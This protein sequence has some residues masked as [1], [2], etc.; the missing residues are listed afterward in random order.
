MAVTKIWPVRDNLKR[1]VEYAENPEKIFLGG[2]GACLPNLA[3]YLTERLGLSVETVNPF[4]NV[5][6][7]S[8]VVGESG[9]SLSLSNIYAPALGLAM[10]KF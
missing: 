8:A 7:D 3:S 1:L 10:R 6:C 2:G 4:R 9:M 5:T